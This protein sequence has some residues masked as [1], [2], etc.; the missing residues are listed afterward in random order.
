MNKRPE[1]PPEVDSEMPSIINTDPEDAFDMAI[2]TT[3]RLEDPIDP[4]K[5]TIEF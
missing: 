4:N 3:L 5:R 1:I 2:G